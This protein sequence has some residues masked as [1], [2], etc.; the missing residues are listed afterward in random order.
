MT[1]ASQ[2]FVGIDLAPRM[3]AWGLALKAQGPRGT[4]SVFA[5][6]AAIEYAVARRN[7]GGASLS[8]QFLNWASHEASGEAG[9]GGF[10]SDIWAGF[11]AYGACAQSLAPYCETYDAAYR[12]GV[13]ALE[14]AAALRRRPFAFHWIKEWDVATGL[15]DEHVAAVEACLRAGWPVC[16]GM[17]WPREAD[18]RD[19]VLR[20]PGDA[21]VYDGHSVL[22]TGIDTDPLDPAGRLWW[23]KDSAA[24]G[25]TRAVPVS[26][27][28]RYV[29][30]LAWVELP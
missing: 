26:Y 3:R 30:D 23:L 2:P 24:G 16:A 17:R 7:A 11:L 6:T 20:V 12:P 14:Q 15:A 4:C 8:E 27:A 1:T 21:E 29:N 18:W 10:F 5:V 22:V 25:C 9:D 13:E 28:R 19:R